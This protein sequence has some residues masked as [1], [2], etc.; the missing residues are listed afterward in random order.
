MTGGGGTGV[1]VVVG[2]VDPTEVPDVVVPE[3]ADVPDVPLFSE[4]VAAVFGWYS[5][6]AQPA[7][8]EAAPIGKAA[9][10]A[11]RRLR[12]AMMSFKVIN[13]S[14]WAAVKRFAMANRSDG[15]ALVVLCL[16]LAFGSAPQLLGSIVFALVLALYCCPVLNPHP[17]MVSLERLGCNM[18]PHCSTRV[19]C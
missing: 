15:A 1:V 13:L 3:V 17:M 16:P 8:M 9:A 12:N 6:S 4:V 14:C 2:L 5:V 7:S 18:S 11:T 10:A 19:A